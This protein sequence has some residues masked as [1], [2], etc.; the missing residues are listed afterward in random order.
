MAKM[1]NLDGK[2][3]EKQPTQS[4]WGGFSHLHKGEVAALPI[5]SKCQQHLGGLFG[6]L[7]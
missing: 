4:K 3:Q 6:S 7:G 2:Q 1:R 5:P